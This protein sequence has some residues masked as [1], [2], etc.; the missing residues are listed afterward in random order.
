MLTI[1]NEGRYRRLC[2]YYE[3]YKI[4]HVIILILIIIIIIIIIISL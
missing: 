3:L 4:A 2:T 1:G